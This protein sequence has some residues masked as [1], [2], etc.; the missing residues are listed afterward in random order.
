MS[1]F[2]VR[3]APQFISY[4]SLWTISHLM[5]NLLSSQE[6]LWPVSLARARCMYHSD[7]SSSYQAYTFHTLTGSSEL[8]PQA[9]SWACYHSVTPALCLGSLPPPNTLIALRDSKVRQWDLKYLGTWCKRMC[10]APTG[11][12]L[13]SR[14][15]HQL[16]GNMR[17]RGAC[18]QAKLELRHGT[19]QIP[20]TNPWQDKKKGVGR[21]WT[22]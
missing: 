17:A 3:F 6:Y 1:Y 14:S 7:S 5:T 16:V 2:R 19:G 20:T 15:S 11:R 9:H 4:Y 8:W 22:C 21:E 13:A 10:T 18:Y 12:V